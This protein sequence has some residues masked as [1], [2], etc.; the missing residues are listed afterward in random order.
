MCLCVCVCL[1]VCSYVCQWCVMST[2][3]ACSTFLNPSLRVLKTRRRRRFNKIWARGEPQWQDYWS[4]DSV[5]LLWLKKK[6]KNQ[7]F[8][9]L[10][11]GRNKWFTSIQ[12]KDFSLKSS[13]LV[14]SFLSSNWEIK[15]NTGI[16]LNIWIKQKKRRKS[17]C[18]RWIIS[19]LIS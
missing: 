12:L 15:E 14:T 7:N 17:F 10:K 6:K 5:L 4:F 13:E 2:L 18:H 19:W 16:E 8:D 3:S 11:S 9:T 1:C